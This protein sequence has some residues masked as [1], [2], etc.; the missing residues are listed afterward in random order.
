MIREWEA[1][2]SL[3][4]C[5]SISLKLD[6][7]SNQI[8]TSQWI[9]FLRREKK[10]ERKYCISLIHLLFFNWVKGIAEMHIGDLHAETEEPKTEHQ[11]RITWF[12]CSVWGK[13]SWI[14][15]W[16][17]KRRKER[18]EGGRQR[19]REPLGFMCFTRGGGHQDRTDLRLE[20]QHGPYGCYSQHPL[21]LKQCISLND[22]G[23]TG[24]GHTHSLSLFYCM[25]WLVCVSWLKFLD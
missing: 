25:V 19:L 22:F 2:N 15:I 6:S 18:A 23:L 12:C 17:S 9:M 1:Q 10:K 16:S 8:H 7:A 11:I 20:L 5:K 3:L 13:P 4:H 14:F 21:F 24:L